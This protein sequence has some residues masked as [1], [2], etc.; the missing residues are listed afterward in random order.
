MGV[1]IVN[2]VEQGVSCKILT[3]VCRFQRESYSGFV[4]H[5]VPVVAGSNPFGPGHDRAKRVLDARFR[6]S[7]R[8][9]R[10][11]IGWSCPFQGVGEPGE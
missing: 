1:A 2:G 7:G 8:L 10:I 4:Q 3:Y 9:E 5:C 6:A 11:F